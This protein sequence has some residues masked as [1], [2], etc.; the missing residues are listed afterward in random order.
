MLTGRGRSPV[1]ATYC[2]VTSITAGKEAGKKC[3]HAEV[4]EGKP[5]G[6]STVQP[7]PQ[8]YLDTQKKTFSNF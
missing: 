8:L 4:K 3:K 1:I 7:F 5:Q 2:F 6:S